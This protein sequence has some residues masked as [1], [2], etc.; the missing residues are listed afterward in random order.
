MASDDFEVMAYK[1]LAY[2]DQCMKDGVTPNI[3]KA[4]ELAKANL[5]YWA[6]IVSSLIDDGL[7]RGASVEHY[8]DTTTEVSAG[9]DFALTIKG[10]AFLRENS[11]MAKA[12]KFLGK[13]FEPV[14]KAAVEATKAL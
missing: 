10:A 4:Q 14:L 1:V 12:R 7:I 13:A 3:G 11:G 2:L 8:Y 9:P 5:T 6:A